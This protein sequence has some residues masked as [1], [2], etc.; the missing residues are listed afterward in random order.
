MLTRW[1]V[2]AWKSDR[3]NELVY[4]YTWHQN[5]QEAFKKKKDFINYL[6]LNGL[7]SLF[8]IQ[9]AEIDLNTHR[10]VFWTRPPLKKLELG[11]ESEAAARPDHSRSASGAFRIN[12]DVIFVVV[13]S[14]TASGGEP[15]ARLVC[16][17][18]EAEAS[19]LACLRTLAASRGALRAGRIVRYQLLSNQFIWNLGKPEF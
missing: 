10:A 14:A 9:R 13:A 18:P 16:A 3:G 8:S 4:S 15:S 6:F 5:K 19:S 1:I 17:H 12:T 7:E 11:R 2:Q